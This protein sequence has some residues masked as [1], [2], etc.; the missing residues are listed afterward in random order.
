MRMAIKLGDVY[1]IDEGSTDPKLRSLS[2]SK[3]PSTSYI[4]ISIESGIIMIWCL[5][6]LFPLYGLYLV[7]PCK[8]VISTNLVL[9]MHTGLVCHAT[10]HPSLMF[11][12][13]GCAFHQYLTVEQKRSGMHFMSFVNNSNDH[14]MLL[15]DN[16][17]LIY[18]YLA[19]LWW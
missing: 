11:W 7:R 3:F 10:N 19:S 4:V 6:M 1:S 17:W 5:Y 15:D 9:S 12:R 13:R 2:A 18:S 8:I 14:D 16:V